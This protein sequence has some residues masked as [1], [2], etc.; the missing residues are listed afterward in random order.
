MDLEQR[1]NLMES[2]GWKCEY[3][4]R[5]V[6]IATGHIYHRNGDETDDRPGNLVVACGGY[7]ERDRTS[8][9]R[10]EQQRANP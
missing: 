6:N 1:R 8:K 2:R 3:C 7:Y 9:S 5:R 4:E 10:Q